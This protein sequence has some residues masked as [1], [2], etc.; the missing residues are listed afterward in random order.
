MRNTIFIKESFIKAIASSISSIEEA[1]SVFKSDI[2]QG[3][4]Y[5]LVNRNEYLKETCQALNSD[6]QK[7]VFISGFQ[8]TGKTE[9][10]NTL[11]YALE[12][13]V[14]NFYYECSPITHL[15]DIILSLFNYLKKI[16]IKNPE[17]KRAFKISNNQSIDERLMNYIKSI[18]IPLLI[19]I[20]GF[21][22]LTNG[23]PPEEQKEL[24]HFLEFLSS[25]PEIKIIISGRSGLRAEAVGAALPTRNAVY[26]EQP[27]TGKKSRHYRR[28]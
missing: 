25:I 1:E 4:L 15:D 28:K 5:N 16:A 9:F 19:V 6:E 26:G 8:G 10:I 20:D 22:N 3:V 12:E 21:E 23:N 11:M 14:L 2:P 27:S 18:N 13:N 24:I 7:L 17:Y